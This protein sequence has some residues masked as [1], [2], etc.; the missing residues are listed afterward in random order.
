M[1]WLLI[2][3]DNPTAGVILEYDGGDTCTVANGHESIEKPRKLRLYFECDQGDTAGNIPDEEQIR[4]RE[5]CTYDIHISSSY[6]CPANCPISHGSI[7]NGRGYCKWDRSITTARCFCDE[8]YTGN[9]CATR[10][11]ASS[12]L[13]AAGVSLIIISIFFVI[14]LAVLYFVVKQIRSL[15]D[16]SNY[17]IFNDNEDGGGNV[18]MATMGSHSG[19]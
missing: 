15:R 17:T 6:G 10:I 3:K 16:P 5:V 11:K 13:T 8:G 14:V 4:E 2:S 9:S 18:P 1:S 7:C 12:S 19:P